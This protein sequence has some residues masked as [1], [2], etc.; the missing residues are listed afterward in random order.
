[1]HQSELN[2]LL[3]VGDLPDFV[4]RA[5]PLV[6]V[7]KL[8]AVMRAV[9]NEVSDW[10]VGG[11]VDKAKHLARWKAL[12]IEWQA[13]FA[14]VRVDVPAFFPALAG[15][16]L[17]QFDEFKRRFN[18]ELAS[19][20]AAGLDSKQA[21]VSMGTGIEKAAD[22]IANVLKT[23]AIVG[24]VGAVLYFAWPFISS[25]LIKRRNSVAT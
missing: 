5:V 17:Q 13:W 24:G 14:Q 22:N 18:A 11:G 3:G 10:A 23:A 16:R 6:E 19:L 15:T 2:H 21:P 25:E 9:D 12:F 8:D 1:M 20:N 4:E 7:E